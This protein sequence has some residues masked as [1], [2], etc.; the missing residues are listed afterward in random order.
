MSRIAAFIGHSFTEED[1]NLVRE[2]LDYFDR[3]AQ[4]DIGFTWVHAENAEPQV[5]SNK[6]LR[7]IEGKN[8]FIGI[9][10]AKE[11]VIQPNNLRR[12]RLD[13]KILIGKAEDF[14][15]K[16]S[17]WIIQEIGLA[18]GKNMSVI[19]LLEEG[20]R[21][22][23]GMQGN[24]EYI[25]FN[26]KEPSK[27]FVKLLE[28]LT[29]L[30]PRKRIEEE[31]AH[32]EKAV[33]SKEHPD[34]E[35]DSSLSEV[36]KDWSGEDYERELF[37]ALL[38][39]DTQR[40]EHISRAFNES[41][42]GKS[43]EDKDTFKAF[44]IHCKRILGKG[45]DTRELTAL[46]EKYPNNNE[47]SLFL[48]MAYTDYQDHN[49]A[50]ELFEKS[51]TTLPKGTTWLIRL[52]KAAVAK[53]MSEK[54]DTTR[55][56]LSLVTPSMAQITNANLTL[57]KYLIEIAEIVKDD[58]KIIAY[59]EAV[60]DL[61]PDDHSLRFSLALKYSQLKQY[62]LS[63]LHYSMIPH[64]QRDHGDWNN[65]GVVYSHLD[66]AAKSVSAYR[67]SEIL[68]GTLAMSNLAHKFI[69]AGFLKE[70]EEI[71][72]KA[73]KIPDFDKQIGAAITGIKDCREKEEER[74]KAL[75]DSAGPQ[76]KFYLEFAKACVK[77]RTG[78]YTLKWKDNAC[79]LTVDIRGD[80]FLAYGAY[81]EEVV[82]A[83][84]L[85]MGIFPHESGKKQTYFVRYEGQ[86][87]GL[88][89]VFKKTV[90][91]EGVKYTMLTGP[92]TKHGLLIISDDLESGKVYLKDDGNKD[93]FYETSNVH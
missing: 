18:L 63:L 91:K 66:L 5:L 40:E 61:R 26:R 1:K 68:G 23:G 19:L 60:L 30:V 11:H 52:C 84:A 51:A 82:S 80:N 28:M 16:T 32:Q 8:L 90:S 43:A 37:R 47:I 62:N 72:E 64:G 48:A 10:T 89:V 31:L 56:L 81:E 29:A 76:R 50:A 92:E 44:T 36:G 49:K 14:R 22:P 93:R 59:S 53:S 45:F 70:A 85:L 87:T 7:L 54:I 86:I 34:I 3:V 42:H 77:Q 75:L 13:R 17:D 69:G 27:C 35:P 6:V 55:W 24:L 20:V 67:Q 12:G 65:T 71:C 58:D 57:F 2:F 74:E 39:N 41:V 83:N 25:T 15:T 78:D 9:C 33:E 4:M 88:G 73:I 38:A 46:N 79:L 21:E